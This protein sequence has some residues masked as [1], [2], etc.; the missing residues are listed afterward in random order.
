MWLIHLRHF[1][2]S[3]LNVFIQSLGSTWLGFGVNVLFAIGTIAITLYL[4]QKKHGKAAMLSHWKDEMS[5]AFRVGLACSVVLYLPIAIYAVGKAVYEEH[6]GLVGVSKGQ[7]TALA[8]LNGEPLSPDI[9]EME[10]GNDNVH[11]KYFVYLTNK[12]TIPAVIH[13]SCD[14][15]IEDLQG[16]MLDSKVMLAR[17]SYRVPSGGNDWIFEID[18]PAWTPTSPMVITYKYLAAVPPKCGFEAR[19]MK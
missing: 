6:E 7:I 1:F 12:T 16:S 14:G 4:V 13:V 10:I 9:H 11:R 2:S 8:R 15:P 3:C 17:P 5:M 19:E 18:S